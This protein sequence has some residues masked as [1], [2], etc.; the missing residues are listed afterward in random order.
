MIPVPEKDLNTMSS[1]VY[2]HTE[3]RHICE[4]NTASCIKNIETIDATKKKD[5]K[6]TFPL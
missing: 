3:S 2:I 5:E 4:M 1:V 6:I